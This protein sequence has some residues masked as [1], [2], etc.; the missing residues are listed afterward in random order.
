MCYP[1]VAEH[2]TSH[3][4]IKHILFIGSKPVAHK[5]AES[6]AKVHHLPSSADVQT[7]TKLTLEL[8]GKDAV[9]VLNDVYSVTDLCAILMRGVF[10][11]AL[12]LQD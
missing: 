8:G 7:L 3:P 9:V 6:A 10:Q 4:E 5:V 1:D 11:V 2:L 12:F